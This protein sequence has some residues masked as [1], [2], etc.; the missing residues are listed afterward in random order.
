[1]CTCLMTSTAFVLLVLLLR[2]VSTWDVALVLDGALLM[3]VH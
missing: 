2:V 1:M 3:D